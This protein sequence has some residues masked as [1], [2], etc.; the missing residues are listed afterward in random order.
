MYTVVNQGMVCS[1]NRF[2]M[3]TDWSVIRRLMMSTRGGRVLAFKSQRRLKRDFLPRI[4]LRGSLVCLIMFT[5]ADDS[6]R[7]THSCID[8]LSCLAPPNQQGHSQ[9]CQRSKDKIQ[10]IGDY[11][12][13]YLG[14]RFA[15]VDMCSVVDYC[16]F[17]FQGTISARIDALM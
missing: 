3:V 4:R 14:N 16:S 1:S 12:W 10:N 11:C 8:W 15:L 7:P 5:V 13:S 9:K 17:W 2:W 6:C